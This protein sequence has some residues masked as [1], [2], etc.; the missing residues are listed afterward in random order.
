MNLL[1][2]KDIFVGYKIRGKIFILSPELMGYFYNYTCYLSY[3]IMLQMEGNE[4]RVV[5]SQKLV[6]WSM[7]LLC[8]RGH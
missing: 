7:E 1:F 2:Q 8:R 4:A 3:R 5:F 6:M